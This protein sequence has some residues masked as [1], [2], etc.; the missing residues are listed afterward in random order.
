MWVLYGVLSGLKR[1]SR[2][3]RH[4]Q[5]L[6]VSPRTDGSKAAMPSISFAVNSSKQDK[7]RLYISL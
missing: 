2:K 3:M 1:V 5:S 6:T 7:A 4:V